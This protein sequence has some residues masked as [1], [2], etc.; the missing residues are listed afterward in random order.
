VLCRHCRRSSLRLSRA[1]VTRPTLGETSSRGCGS[2]IMTSMERLV[3][4]LKLR[5]GTQEQAAKLIAAGPPFDRGDL[6][7]A[8]HGSTSATTSR[9]S[10]SKGRP[11]RSGSARSSTIRSARHR[12]RP[13][14][15][16]SPAAPRLPTRSTTGRRTTSRRR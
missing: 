4:T 6:G 5:K 16:S 13:G 10:R 12:S 11:S 14:Y 3:V 9:S 7:I 1:R 8:R 2:R 15:P